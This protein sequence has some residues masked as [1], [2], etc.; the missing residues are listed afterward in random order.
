[1]RYNHFKPVSHRKQRANNFMRFTNSMLI[2]TEEPILLNV[3]GHTTTLD[4]F[5]KDNSG[6]GVLKPPIEELI[7]VAALR[8]GQ[9]MY[10]WFCLIER[11]M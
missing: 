3:E 8:V 1:M 11:I 5:L 10:I 7:E 6:P 9:S 4:D 2:D